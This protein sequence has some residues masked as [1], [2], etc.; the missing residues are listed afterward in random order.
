LRAGLQADFIEL[1]VE[2][3]QQLLEQTFEITAALQSLDAGQRFVQR[4]FQTV[5]GWGT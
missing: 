4:L 2:L 3:R 5:E 1:A